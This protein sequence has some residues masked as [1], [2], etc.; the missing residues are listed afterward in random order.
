MISLNIK[1][2]KNFS[3]AQIA[4]QLP[5]ATALALSKTVGDAQL[6]IGKE[7]PRLFT[8]RGPWWKKGSKFGIKI[9]AAEKSD[10]TPTAEVGT[11]ADWL[12]LHEGGGIKKRRM[13]TGFK[14]NLAA[15]STNESFKRLVK[16]KNYIA[17]PTRNIKRTKREII[18][19][20]M[21]PTRLTRAFAIETRRGNVL[22]MNRP[23]RGKKTKAVPMYLLKMTARIADESA[24]I[25]PGVKT[26]L[27]NLGF[28][29]NA[30]LDKLLK[31]KKTNA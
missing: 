29:F 16:G 31:P 7:L 10:P 15:I 2:N 25:R 17:I 14:K 19:R 1:I 8:I 11:D 26:I 21:R 30:A 4:G 12:Q 24:V 18:R 13:T 9:K 5:K 23:G 6:E 3:F 28:N 27:H 22:I 20:S